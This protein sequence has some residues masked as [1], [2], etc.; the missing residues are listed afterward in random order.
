MSE[1]LRVSLKEQLP[2]KKSS[3]RAIPILLCL[4]LV[5]AIA[6][7]LFLL[8]GG[9]MKGSMD[10][11]VSSEKLQELALKLEKQNLPRAASRAW[12]N[13]L[14]TARPDVNERARVWYRIGKSHQ[15]AGEYERA[16]EAYYRSESLARL[17]DIEAEI[18]RRTVECLESLG[19]YAAVRH[20][21]EE[22]TAYAPG[23]TTGAGVVAEIGPWKITD[24]ELDAMIEG[25]IDAQLTQLAGGFSPEERRQQKKRILEEV[26]SQGGKAM[27]LE[28]FIAEELL[29]RKAAEEKF[30]ED[31]EIRKLTRTIERRL[32]AQK[33]LE[34]QYASSIQVTPDELQS[35]YASHLEEYKEGDAQRPFEEVKEQVYMAVRSQKEMEI[36]RRVLDELMD[37][38]D[39]VIHRSKL[40]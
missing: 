35:Y 24:A 30:Y 7:L 36:Q 12:I 14:D 31:P 38:Y 19:K 22:R 16:L 20:E 39:V 3:S 8:K 21:L 28:R 27:W 32:L 23:D 15:E 25:E 11:G 37:H 6:N 2:K 9:G 5:V 10:A 13:Y 4:I 40:Q 29:Y 26:L 18:S 1:E 34:R 33:Y 17:G